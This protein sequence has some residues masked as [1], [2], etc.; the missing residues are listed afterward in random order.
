MTVL[1]RWFVPPPADSAPPARARRR[2]TK[3]RR[4]ARPLPPL[5]VTQINPAGL[6]DSLGM[7]G[8]M[9]DIVLPTIRRLAHDHKTVVIT[10]LGANGVASEREIEPYREWQSGSGSVMLTAWCLKSGAVRTFDVARV[11]SARE[12]NPFEPR[13]DIDIP[14]PDD[15]AQDPDPTL[16]R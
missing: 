10:Y 2:V 11:Q 14:P 7:V 13:G 3:G 4:T 15:H 16:D 6:E 5:P 9:L 8:D 1:R 12:G